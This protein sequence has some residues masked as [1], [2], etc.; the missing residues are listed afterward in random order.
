MHMMTVDTGIVAEPDRFKLSRVRL[1]F[2]LGS[3][4]SRP[5]AEFFLAVILLLTPMLGRKS[6]GQ[7]KKIRERGRG[8][9]R[10]CYCTGPC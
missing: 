9:V 10:R 4:E 3:P 2:G 7:A 5:D 6:E 1:S 8:N